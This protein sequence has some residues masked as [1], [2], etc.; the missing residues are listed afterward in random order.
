M[1]TTIVIDSKNRKP[2]IESL[3]TLIEI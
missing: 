2:T 3:H 1:S